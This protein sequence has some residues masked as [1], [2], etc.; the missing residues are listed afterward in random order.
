M[1]RPGLH[2]EDVI[3]AMADE[4]GMVDAYDVEV[5]SSQ[6]APLGRLGVVELVQHI[7]KYYWIRYLEAPLTRRSTNKSRYLST[8]PTTSKRRRTFL[9]VILEPR[10][11]QAAEGGRKASPLAEQDRRA[12]GQGSH[13]VVRRHHR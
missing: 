7:T 1:S 3:R 8:T 10:V 2:G 12:D 4:Y 13:R 9:L 11:E 6:K 5:L